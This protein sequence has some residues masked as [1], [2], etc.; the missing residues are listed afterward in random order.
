MV[1]HTFTAGP[2]GRNP[3][4]G[5]VADSAGNLYGTTLAGGA[6]DYGTVFKLARTR[7]ETV[8]YSFQWGSTGGSDGANPSGNLVRDGAGNLY[9]TTQIGGSPDPCFQVGCGIVF[10]LDPSGRET[11]LHAF[12]DEPDGANPVT[13]V[14]RDAA[15]NLYGTTYVGGPGGLSGFGTVFMLDATGQ[16]TVLYRFT[17]G[18]DGAYPYGSLLLDPSGNLYGTTST[19]GPIDVEAGVVFRITP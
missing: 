1:L 4:G 7:F 6:Y 17:G 19:G 12:N 2:D 16:E 5:L 3:E 18:L 10:K 9:G 14:V 15:G 8:L 13:G 11:V